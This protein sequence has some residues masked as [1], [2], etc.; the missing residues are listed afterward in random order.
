M[1]HT[2]TLSR[3]YRPIVFSFLLQII[4]NSISKFLTK[5]FFHEL[6]TNEN[7]ISLRVETEL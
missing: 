1:Q 5:S 4:Q 3:K 7:L 2:Y 6:E